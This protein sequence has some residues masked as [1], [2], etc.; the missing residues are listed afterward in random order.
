MLYMFYTANIFQRLCNHLAD[1][2]AVRL[3]RREGTVVAVVVEKFVGVCEI[4]VSGEKK[5]MIQFARFVH[6]WMAERHVVFPE[7]GVA[8]MT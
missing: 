2:V 1:E 6:E 8:K 4:E 3:A 5:R 7:R